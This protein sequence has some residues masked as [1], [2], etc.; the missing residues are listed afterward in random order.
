LVL[1]G[2]IF[3][4]NAQSNPLAIEHVSTGAKVET[5]K[6]SLF[7]HISKM[8]GRPRIELETDTRLLIKNKIQEYYQEVSVKIFDPEGKPILATGAKMRARGNMRKKVSYLPPLKIDFKKSALDALGFLRVDDLKL[9]LPANSSNSS[10]EKLYQEHFLY[11]VYQML[12]T[13]AI[14]TKLVDVVIKYKGKEKYNLTGFLIEDEEEYERRKQVKIIER[15]IVNDFMLDKVSFSKMVF[16]QYMIGNTDF[17]VKARHNIEMVRFP[18]K[19]QIV[20]VPYDFDYSGFV[21]QGYAIPHPD[22]PIDNVRKRYFFSGYKLNEEDYLM[23]IQYY[24]SFEQQI[25]QYCD[26]VSYMNEKTKAEN[27]KYLK[28]FF[29][30]LYKRINFEQSVG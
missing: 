12:D 3:L 5:Y 26:E 30:V 19:T 9:V 27:K 2:N 18:D 14:K 16:F 25:I 11:E 8:N 1:S 7:D 4:L 23:M 10:Q 13:N 20:V 22:L 6:T 21:N 15:G 24:L 28:E 29:K 17:S